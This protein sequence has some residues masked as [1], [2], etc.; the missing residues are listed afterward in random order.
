MC[1]S[2]PAKS[3]PASLLTNSD[4][5][6]LA[7]GNSRPCPARGG[8]DEPVLSPGSADAGTDAPRLWSIPDLRMEGAGAGARRR[9]QVMSWSNRRSANQLSGQQCR[10]LEYIGGVHPIAGQ[11]SCR[12]DACKNGCTRKDQSPGSE[13]K[14]CITGFT[15]HSCWLD[16]FGCDTQRHLSLQGWPR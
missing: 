5:K 14:V 7:A 12:K 15:V 6:V 4:C 9:T 2:E 3:V 8:G 13:I 11:G 1:H 10:L 16:S